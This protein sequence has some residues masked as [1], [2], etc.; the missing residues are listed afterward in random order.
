MLY[1]QTPINYSI[2]SL[3]LGWGCKKLHIRGA[4]IFIYFGVL[5]YVELNE[6]LQQRSR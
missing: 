5:G 4:E 2:K 1:T 3:N 6:N